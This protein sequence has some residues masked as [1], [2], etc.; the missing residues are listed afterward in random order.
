VALY[1]ALV[2]DVL[3]EQ[4]GSRASVLIEGRFAASETFVRALASLRRDLHIY[5]SSGHDG[6]C[7]GALRL[8]QPRLAP[9]HPLRRVAPLDID[10]IAYKAR[11]RQLAAQQ[12]QVS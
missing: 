2:S 6:V 5:V 10:L 9:P 3:L 12:E 8:V 1:A 7:H 11:W 4:I